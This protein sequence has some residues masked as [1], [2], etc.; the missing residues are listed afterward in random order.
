MVREQTPDIIVLDW[1]I[2]ELSG[3]EVC[4]QLRRMEETANIPI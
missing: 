3:I 2:E 4:R 1:M